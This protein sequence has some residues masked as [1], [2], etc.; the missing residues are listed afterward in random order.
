ME[1]LGFDNIMSFND[2]FG[3]EAEEQGNQV[4]QQ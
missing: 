3:G 1:E 4:V 2:L